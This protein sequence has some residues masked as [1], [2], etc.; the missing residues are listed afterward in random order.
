MQTNDLGL[1]EF[2]TLCKT[3]RSGAIH[4]R[5]RGLRRLAL[6]G[7]RGRVHERIGQHVYGGPAREIRP[8]GPYRIKFWNIGNEPWVR[9]SLGHMDLK[10]YLLKHNEFAKAMRAVDPS[11]TLIASGMMLQ[12]D[13]VPP[14]LR[15]K[16]VGNLEPLYGSDYDWTGGFL[17]SCWGN[18]DI[19]AEHW[20]AN[21]GHHGIWRR[22]GS[23]A[24]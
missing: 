1:D 12:N 6:G 15:A 17:K 19:I 9:G 20:Y 2:M 11:I 14:E 10:Y 8:S 4:Q 22:K 7:G 5:Q 21:G 16:N 18:F 24:G 3:H 23:C 13:N